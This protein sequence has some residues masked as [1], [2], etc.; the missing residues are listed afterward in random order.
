MVRGIASAACALLVLLSIAGCAGQSQ[1]QIQG[2]GRFSDTP[3]GPAAVLRVTVD[4]ALASRTGHTAWGAINTTGVRRRFAACVAHAAAHVGGMDVLPALVV[5]QKLSGPDREPTLQPTEEQ[6][7]RHVQ[8][9]GLSSYMVVNVRRSRLKYVFSYCWAT[10]EY[11]LSCH[12]AGD[13]R[14]LWRV[15]VEFKDRLVSDQEALNE[16]LRRTFRWLRRN[17]EGKESTSR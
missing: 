16:A 10:V 5:E 8:E 11:V 2:T 14:L 12:A 17:P 4:E 13:G 6:L 7:C 1:F 9:L 15:D 3:E